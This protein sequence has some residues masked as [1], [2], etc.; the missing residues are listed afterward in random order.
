V[1]ILLALLSAALYGA[2]DFLGGIATRRARWRPL[3]P[4]PRAAG[5]FFSR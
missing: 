5:F 4:S 3:S 2:A 1:I